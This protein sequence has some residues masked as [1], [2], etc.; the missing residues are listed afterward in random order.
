MALPKCSKLDLSEQ[1]RSTSAMPFSVT[2]VMCQRIEPIDAKKHT[3]QMARQ[4]CVG[5]SGNSTG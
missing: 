2:H 1:V 3:K 5:A 4:R